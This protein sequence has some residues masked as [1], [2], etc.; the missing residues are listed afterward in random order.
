MIKSQSIVKASAGSGKTH[1][2]SS[3]ILSLLFLKENPAR[4]LASTFT[5]KASGEMF[6][7]VILRLLKASLSSEQLNT[8]LAQ[9]SLEDK[10]INYEQL[11]LVIDR[12]IK[13]QSKIKISTLDSFFVSLGKAFFSELSLPETWKISDKWEVMALEEE[14]FEETIKSLGKENT[15]YLLSLLPKQKNTSQIRRDILSL[16]R[17]LY[18]EFLT[19]P[20]QAWGALSKISSLTDSNKKPETSYLKAK[21]QLE[22]PQ[23]VD[24]IK[25]HKNTLKKAEEVLNLFINNKTGELLEHSF[26]N[27]ISLNKTYQ[28]HNKP[29]P[30]SIIEGINEIYN[31]ARAEFFNVIR[32]ESLA[33]LAILS[34][35]QKQLINLS[36]KNAC[37]SFQDLTY[38]I[39]SSIGSLSLN[40][41][42]YR[43]DSNI[44]HMLLDEFQDTSPIQWEILE[45]LASELL[46]KIESQR[47]FLIVGDV[48]QAIYAWRGGTS[49]LFDTI[50]NKYPQLKSSEI[51]L[52]KTYRSS[53]LVVDFINKIFLELRDNP[54]L[55]NYPDAVNRWSSEFITHTPHKTDAKGD[56]IVKTILIENDKDSKLLKSEYMEQ[57]C[58]EVVNDCKKLLNDSSIK[59]IGILT[60]T[61]SQINLLEKHFN[62][63]GIEVKGEGREVITNSKAVQLIISALKLANHP[64][65]TF[66]YEHLIDS[67]LKEYILGLNNSSKIASHIASPEEVS[68]LLYNIYLS[69]GI[70]KFIRNMLNFLS[71]HIS[72]SELERCLSILSLALGYERKG[73]ISI[74]NFINILNQ[75]KYGTDSNAK[76]KI[77]TIHKSKGLEF[78]AVLIPFT[79]D[80]FTS[81]SFNLLKKQDSPIE[82]AKIVVKNY[83]QK[84]RAHYPELEEM[85]NDAKNN[86]LVEG[87]SLTYVALTRAIDSLYIYLFPDDTSLE[88]INNKPPSISTIIRGTFREHDRLEPNTIL[89]KKKGENSFK[90]ENCFDNITQIQSI[91]KSSSLDDK[92]ENESSTLYPSKSFLVPEF[93]KQKNLHRVY[94]SQKDLTPALKIAETLNTE[95]FGGSEFGSR[96]HNI[97]KNIS[98]I[99]QFPCNEEFSKYQ[100]E[101]SYLKKAFS[102]ESVQNVFLRENYTSMGEELILEREISFSMIEHENLVSGRLDRLL[103]M[104]KNQKPHSALI[105]DFKTGQSSKEELLNSQHNS[106]SNFVCRKYK[107]D[108]EAV[109]TRFVFLSN[110]R[111][112][113]F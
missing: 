51:T 87:L 102:F 52:T 36:I 110:G 25:V 113:E 10:N 57:T 42:Y 37:F 58:F 53:P 56:I 61:N 15:K 24:G 8:L 30:A 41:I 1:Y 38:L 98:W 74:E 14:A 88:A 101:N 75:S 6:E 111:V 47:S 43:L 86:S 108:K 73:S 34:E 112:F 64:L 39:S 46:S 69:Q 35:Y 90:V 96:I 21:L 63:N 67:P 94:P 97:L 2:L 13:N 29:I 92:K 11:I 23:E 45:P 19:T 48:K 44:S 16:M 89:Y 5:K 60:R 95:N 81:K 76:I 85:H 4:I 28:Y 100:D 7:R 93:T 105:L 72:Q 106:Y 77:M 71:E 65:D 26:L 17:G 79:S 18:S 22:H 50:T 84:L 49:E 66:S 104:L 9:L 31:Y 70:D 107:L 55:S 62:E 32:N 3:H 78:D 40:E 82:D 109:K 91:N 80:E 68:S 59:T 103:V 12:L 33:L 20:P 54:A 83:N 99:E 27:L